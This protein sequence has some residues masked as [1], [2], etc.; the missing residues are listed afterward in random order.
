LSG[1]RWS[2]AEALTISR[3]I[4]DRRGE[5]FWGWNLGLLYEESEWTA[6]CSSP[7]SRIQLACGR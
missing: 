4:G 2:G 5:A 6:S 3:E 1:P 7:A